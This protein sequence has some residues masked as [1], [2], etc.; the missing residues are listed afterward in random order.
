MRNKIVL[1]LMV[2]IVFFL[3]ICSPTKALERELVRN[4]A[5]Q[6][7]KTAS[8]LVSSYTILL[9][10]TNNPQSSDDYKIVTVQRVDANNY[11]KGIIHVKTKSKF[12]NGKEN[13]LQSANYLSAALQNIGANV[14]KIFA[15]NKLIEKHPEMKS[16]GFD[17]LYE[18]NIPIDADPVN[19][20]AELMQNPDVEYACP[21]Y[22]RYP[23]FNPNDPLKTQQYAIGNMKLTQAWDI[24]QGDPTITIAIVDSGTDWSHSDLAANIWSNPNETINGK[25]DDG[26]GKIDDVRG[27]DFCA[28]TNLT[29]FNQGD[30]GEDNNPTNSVNTHG[31]SVAGC[32]SASTNNS[33]GIASPGFNC[34]I[35]PVKMGT[36][37]QGREGIYRAYEG[38]TYAAN[39]GA[40]IINCSWGGIGYSA[41][42]EQVINYAIKTKGCFVVVSSGNDGTNNDNFP[43]YPCNYPGVFSVGATSSSNAMTNFSNFG[44]TVHSFAPGASIYTT[45]A[46]NRYKTIDGTS[47]SSPYTSGVAGLVLSVA[48]KHNQTW[49]PKKLFHQLRST[50]DRNVLINNNLVDFVYGSI[51]AYKAVTYN[52]PG[53]PSVPGLSIL[54]YTIDGKATYINNHDLHNFS[55]VVKNYLGTASNLKITA[56]SPDA[57]VECGAT[58][59]QLNS[60]NSDETHEINISIKINDK[61]PWFAGYATFILKY[62]A[63][64]YSDF[65]YIKIPINLPTSNIYTQLMQLPVSTSWNAI[66]APDANTCWAVGTGPMFSNY[67]GFI[68][69]YNG[70]A[71]Y[72][73]V[74]YT[75]AYAI[76]GIDRYIAFI[77]TSYT[78]QSMI[79]K[80]VNAGNNWTPVSV[81]TITDFINDLHFFNTSNGVMLGDPK[82]SKWGVAYTQNGGTYWNLSSIPLPLSDES[83]MVGASATFGETIWFGTSAGRTFRSTDKGRSWN[84][85]SQLPGA[86]HKYAFLNSNDGIAI[87]ETN[88]NIL[89]LAVTNN[90]GETWTTKVDNL[91]LSGIYPVYA[92]GVEKAKAFYLVD[93]QGAIFKTIDDGLSWTMERTNR[94]NLTSRA[95]IVNNAST[96]TIT[97]FD[98]GAD[99]GKLQFKYY[100]P[101]AKAAIS[102]ANGSE[103]KF[104]T[105]EVNSTL[106][107]LIK[108][109]NT[110]ELSASI[111][112][113]TITPL[114]NT[115]ENEF[116]LN[117]P[118]T[119]LSSG[120]NLNLN[121]KFAPTSTGDKSARLALHYNGSPDTS[122]IILK[123][124]SKEKAIEPTYIL[125]LVSN[126]SIDFDTVALNK[127][128]PKTITLKNNGN[129]AVS[130]TSISIVDDTNK[131]ATEFLINKAEIIKTIEP[132]A[133][134]EI[135][136]EFAPTSTGNKS[137]ILSITRTGNISPI[138]VRL[139]GVGKDETN[140]VEES[141]TNH[142]SSIRPNPAKDYLEV[143]CENTLA[144]VTAISIFNHN[145][146][147]VLATIPKDK[148]A[149]NLILNTSSIPS[150]SYQLLIDRNG[151]KETINIIIVK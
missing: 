101:D 92:F 110:G 143:Y 66:S 11:Q 91:A 10:K 119:T 55:A 112:Q 117:S 80:T 136:V 61:C 40:K 128:S 138:Q 18:I 14:S 146:E 58:P 64:G 76:C 56:Y 140:S 35:I 84:V 132:N 12:D 94:D 54:G 102:F 47:F 72:N 23:N 46:S 31:T 86:I 151:I 75:P 71:I 115:E 30:F 121:V 113:S 103:Y 69:S 13:L 78:N 116:I 6:I 29:Q 96:N 4:F 145:G 148:F 129:Q 100:A 133:E 53:G 95:D 126:D 137:A 2:A 57:F 44:Y 134:L 106:T 42:E 108:I 122:F 51:N 24:T 1:Q 63:D 104:D 74:S 144:D 88:T 98:I 142:A 62:E 130:I 59:I 149:K 65:E 93:S 27:W 36:E 28:T 111:S 16:T 73:T 87:Y 60:L 3:A 89:G 50:S 39:L 67:T 99:L 124:Y 22:V 120:S 139:L 37:I 123:A 33:I 118:P 9:P 90:G 48:K 131:E 77:G 114:D 45:E 34:K 150:G 83:G 25:D 41:A 21:I 135:I 107:K 68:Q 127:K 17:R 43:N 19:I 52:F 109:T 8:G 81:A 5:T 49:T 97:M 20:C 7:E 32:A 125:D 38:I 141:M 85:I 15:N 26:N 82:N 79:Y 147:L 105:T 70:T